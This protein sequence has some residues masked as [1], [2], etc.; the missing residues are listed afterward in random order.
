LF[1]PGQESSVAIA[2]LLGSV[3]NTGLVMLLVNAKVESDSAISSISNLTRSGGIDVTSVLQGKYSDFTAAWYGDVGVAI[4]IT[5][6]IYVFSPHFPPLARYCRF[7]CKDRSGSTQQQL[8]SQHVGPDFHH[9]IRY[10]QITVVIFV[11]MAYS[12]GI[13]VL[14]VEKNSCCFLLYL[15]EFAFTASTASTAS[16]AFTAFTA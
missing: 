11:S 5:M 14:Y 2:V 15:F 8:N 13:P 9:S 6:L 3:L 4:T 10:P 1:H 12:T 7:N 16:T